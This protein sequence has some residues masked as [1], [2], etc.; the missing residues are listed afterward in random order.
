MRFA[1]P[2]WMIWLGLLGLGGCA[3]V[4]SPGTETRFSAPNDMKY[5]NAAGSHL[6]TW[7]AQGKIAVQT[8]HKGWNASFNWQ[9]SG[10]NYW[11]DLFGPLG[12]NRISLS[13][14][15]QYA[16]LQTGNQKDEA[17][18]AEMLLKRR[19]GWYL[20]VN[21]VHYWIRGVPAPGGY[22]H[23]VRQSKKQIAML[24]QQGWHIT[25]KAYQRI[26]GLDLPVL[27]EM[28]NPRV[29]IRIAIYAWDL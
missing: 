8:A 7:E 19:L 20:P 28:E 23:L 16:L 13:G 12:A 10:H 24:D 11:L 14:N 27:I 3:T 18:N 17:P 1:L 25:Y 9:Q 6:A 15:P 4:S 5:F 22:D 2:R 29:F 26:N 21:N